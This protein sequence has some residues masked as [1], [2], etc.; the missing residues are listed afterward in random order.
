MVE[1][2]LFAKQ[3]RD[4]DIENKQKEERDGLGDWTDIYP[5]L[6]IRQVTNENLLR[7]T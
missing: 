2:N 1:M 4:S 6:C 5:L 3:N 7:S